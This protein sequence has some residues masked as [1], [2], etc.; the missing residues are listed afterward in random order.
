MQNPAYLTLSRHRIY[1]FRFP[2]PRAFHPQGKAS[3]IRISLQ[4]RCPV[5]ALHLSQ[6]LAY[7]GRRAIQHQAIRHMDY[8]HIRAALT[9]HFQALLA[10]RKEEMN[11]QGR[12][13]IE[14]RALLQTNADLNTDAL[15]NQDYSLTGT[16]DTVDNFIDAYE[17]PIVKGSKSYEDLRVGL[18]EAHR[19]YC[20][21]V[22]KHDANLGHYNFNETSLPAKPVSNG[23]RLQAILDLYIEEKSRSG[24]WRGNTAIERQTQLAVLTEFLGTDAFLRIDTET[25]SSIKQL[26]SRLPRNRKKLYPKLSLI[27]ASKLE[28]PNDARMSVSNINKHINAYS[29]FYTW[30]VKNHHTDENP[31]IGLPLGK[32][33]NDGPTKEAFDDEAVS[34]IYKAIAENHQGLVNLPYQKWGPLIAMLTG[35]RANEIAQMELKDIKQ[36]KGIWYFD[37]NDETDKGSGVIKRLKNKAS[38]R[39]IPVHSRLIEL[40]LLD[41]VEELRKEGKKRLLHELTYQAKSGYARELSRW[42]N[43]TLLPAL[44]LK[45]DEL[46]LHCFRHTMSGR[47]LSAGIELAVMQSIIGHTKRETVFR[48]YAA[49][50]H[51]LEIKLNAIE[52]AFKD[53]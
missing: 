4:T 31:F 25:A 50:P 39:T 37:I 38:K 19:D 11:A 41:Y 13:S 12:L 36:E 44:N 1:L 26:F 23:K 32:N 51:T 24:E 34:K 46:T 7:F 45:K 17:L 47:I 29:A 9:D 3:E 5:T 28:L 33:K 10:R 42:F 21:A 49:D 22:L 52:K 43:E 6:S 15:D 35:A 30:A 48:Y 16:N 8:Q 53:L 2:L 14:G 18:L 40:G 27:E 20:K